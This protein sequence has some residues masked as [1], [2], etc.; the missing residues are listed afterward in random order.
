MERHI[1]DSESRIISLVS[2]LTPQL[3][4]KLL[5]DKLDIIAEYQRVLKISEEIDEVAVRKYTGEDLMDYSERMKFVV[6]NLNILK[7]NVD[8]L[9]KG[10]N[11]DYAEV[12]H[13]LAYLMAELN[14]LGR[15]VKYVGGVAV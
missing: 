12:A 7:V 4:E 14:G 1:L 10:V 5:D 8:L 3:L 13:S 6:K 15:T 2:S 11:P 9:S